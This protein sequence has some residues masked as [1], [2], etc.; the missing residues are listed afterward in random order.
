[1]SIVL[2]LII[3]LLLI[4]LLF[5]NRKVLF[6]LSKLNEYENIINKQGERN[7]EYK[8]QL[9]VLKGY[10]DD[11]EKLNE[12]LEMLIGD[13]KTGENYE[14]RQLSRLKQLGIKQLLY[15]KIEKIKSNKI[16]F[17]PYISD[18][19]SNS[20]NKFDLFMIK[21]ITKLLGILMDNA[22]DASK[23]S[24]EKEIFL[25]MTEEKKYINI[26]IMNSIKDDKGL[27]NIGKKRYSTKGKNHGFGLLL[28]KEIVRKNKKLELVTD[29]DEN[30]FSQTIL[31]DKK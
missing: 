4:F 28:A 15:F 21:D 20:F 25:Y 22:I 8:N 13:H 2:L 18:S 3:I 24:K 17:C 23:K 1:M 12:Y 27:K 11:K 19:I 7:H 14:V 16:K 29:I 6:L 9:I 30:M 10:I 5:L 26:K 31:I